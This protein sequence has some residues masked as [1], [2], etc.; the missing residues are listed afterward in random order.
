M[1]V[2]KS[3]SIIFSSPLAI[4]FLSL[5]SYFNIASMYVLLDV[6]LPKIIFEYLS[7]LFK[8]CSVDFLSQAGFAWRMQPWAE[9]RVDESRA[10]HF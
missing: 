3:F 5:F 8:S 4:F 6:K 7:E 9:E 1:V 2:K 10:L